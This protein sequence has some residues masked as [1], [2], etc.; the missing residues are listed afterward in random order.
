MKTT[1]TLLLLA[2]FFNSYA[3]TE[4][5]KDTIITVPETLVAAQDSVV[6]SPEDDKTLDYWHRRRFKLNLGIY[7]PVNNTEV[8]VD[9]SRGNFGTNIDLEDDLGFEK[10]TFSWAGSFQWRIS[11]RSRLDFEYFYLNR[12]SSHTIDREINFGD[13]T[14]PINARIYAFFD[15]QIA[16][17]SYGY[18]FISKPKY[19][20]GAVLGVHTIFGKIGLGLETAS[21]QAEVSDDFD[22][23][24]PLPDLGIWGDVVLSKKFGLFANVS[25]LGVKVEDI[26]GRIVSTN[27][28]LL[29]NVYHN[30]NLT[31]GYTGMWIR[32]D[33]DKERADG[34]FKWGYHGPMLT[35]AYTFGK[36][37]RSTKKV[38]Q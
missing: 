17:L 5:T 1:F 22:F 6:I 7:F 25:Y 32:V 30:F 37:V 4:T 2:V 10:E 29:Y 28:S 3:Q 15:M 20:I 24:A 35:A 27:L 8:Q 11:R 12:E 16:R 21:N 31:L 19:E 26:K 9:G 34:F 38:K 14:Y 33:V 18:A 23:T 36:N 13:N